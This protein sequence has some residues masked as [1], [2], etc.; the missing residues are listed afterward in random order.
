MYTYN[1]SKGK[2]NKM[3]LK[4]RSHDFISAARILA[5]VRP[6]KFRIENLKAFHSSSKML[7]LL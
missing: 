4:Q 3:K 6:T 5:Q 7:F 1:V 2:I